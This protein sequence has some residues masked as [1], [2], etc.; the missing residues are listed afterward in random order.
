M[1]R[2]D[3]V[4]AYLTAQTLAGGS[5][6][7]DLI[8]R[9]MGD[10]PIKDQ[11]VVVSEDGGPEPEIKTAAGIGSAAVG[12][13]GVL[14]TVRAKEWDGNTSKAK[15]VAILA[16]LHGLRNV[17]LVGGGTTYY[18]IRALTP[19]PVFAG[20]DDTGRPRHT[21]GFRLLAALT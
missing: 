17:Q 4:V 20:F 18:R 2:V 21:V 9:K 15:A 7:W 3:D 12:D 8:L 6:G 16:A 5:T 11:V 1:S 14:I 10:T 19:E 13:G